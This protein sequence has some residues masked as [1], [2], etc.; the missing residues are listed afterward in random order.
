[1][2]VVV[3]SKAKA[4]VLSL[5]ICIVAILSF[6]HKLQAALSAPIDINTPILVLLQQHSQ[7]LNRKMVC[8]LIFVAKIAFTTPMADYFQKNP[9]GSCA[10]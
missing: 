6:V 9:N 7:F 10:K 4:S 5:Q 1:M 3:S 8:R 2:N